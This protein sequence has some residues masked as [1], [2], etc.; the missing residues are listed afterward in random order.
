MKQKY[1]MLAVCMCAIGVAFADVIQP[2]G[3]KT[4]AMDTAAIQAALD[5]AAAESPAGT[6]T[7]GEGLFQVN[8]QLMVT[9][10]V[11]LTGQGYDKTILKYSSS[12]LKTEVVVSMAGNSTLKCLT[13]TGGMNQ[14]GNN[15]SHGGGVYVSGDADG[16]VLVSACC[17]TNNCNMRT[18]GGGVYVAGKGTVKIERSII[19]NNR[20]A[21]NFSI[22]GYGGGIGVN[23]SDVTVVIDACLV[24]GNAIGNGSEKTQCG[25][26]LGVKS[27]KS[28][29]VRNTTIVG[30]SVLSGGK[31]GGFY[32]ESAL[33]FVNCIFADNSA[34]T[35]ANVSF[36]S[37]TTQTNTGKKSSNC[38]FCNGTTSFGTNPVCV[39]GSAGFV[40]PA[41][42]DYHLLPSSPAVGIGTAY[43]DIGK[44]LD[45]SD[46]ANPP[47]AGCYE[48]DG[49][50]PWTP[51]PPVLGKLTV[52]PAAEEA[53]ISGTISALGSGGSACDVYLAVG[54]SAEALGAAT[55]IAES[56][57]DS[58]E[59]TI[60]DLKPTTSY[61]FELSVTNNATPALG[62][63]TNGSFTTTAKSDFKR[64]VTFT[65][66]YAAEGASELS[67]IPVLVKLSEGNPVG[68]KYSDC[69]SGGRDIR[70]FDADGEPVPFEIDTWNT[71]GES[72]IWVKAPSIAKGTTFTMFYK[73]NPKG[74]SAE[75]TN[76]QAVWTAYT[77]VWHLNG[78]GADTTEHSQGLYANA[79]ATAGIDAH[80]SA[81]SI[82]N[83]TGKFGKA[84]RT[85]DSTG[86]N[87]G[88]WNEGGAWVVDAGTDSPIDSDNGKLT[89]SCW[90]K[91]N[92]W[93]NSYGEKIIYKRLTSNGKPEADKP[94]GSFAVEAQ[95]SVYDF[96]FTAKASSDDR[97]RDETSGKDPEPRANWVYVTAVYDSSNTILL[98]VNADKRGGKIYIAG[99]TDNDAPLVFGNNVSIASGATGDNAWNGWID[100][101]R[102]AKGAKSAAWIAAEYAAMTDDTF[103]TAGDVEKTDE[104]FILIVR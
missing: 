10:G 76:P 33:A 60:T 26:G 94:T 71:S 97:A 102:Y 49:D 88:N 54:P 87:Q 84:F 99:V 4:G 6:V 3:D 29:T 12:K 22:K 16:T 62:I 101:V 100:E 63:V 65:V 82:P 24:A 51:D 69:L 73:G 34:P 20:S 41:M 31:G 8:A 48:L 11:T 77:G 37:T 27:S 66:G 39:E 40:A 32:T 85:N 35:D 52:A 89:V 81:N 42:G 98:Y 45:G 50:V 38:L 86:L 92:D 13:V 23:S 19:A 59:Y 61:F 15:G 9:N 75:P 2:S 55:K 93:K 103:V 44:D 74:T 79:T 64:K 83:E 58:F 46:F 25:G 96:A 18:Y 70:F 78:L 43:A 5:A 68:F 90:V 1:S 7:L 80:L 56:V 28:V 72:L 30:N 95:R 57:K 104:G 36:N 47:S 17:I 91:H 53:T 14:N 21:T 67:G